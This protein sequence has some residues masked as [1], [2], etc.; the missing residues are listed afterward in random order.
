MPACPALAWLACMQFF[1]SKL[2]PSVVMFVIHEIANIGQ[3][4]IDA[5]RKLHPRMV[6][7]VMSPHIQRYADV[8]ILDNATRMA[9]QKTG[10][11]FMWFLDVMPWAPRL[12]GPVDDPPRYP[13]TRMFKRA[14]ALTPQ[15]LDGFV[16]NSA[17]ER[18]AKNLQPLWDGLEA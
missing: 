17:H 11:P 15:C 3:G 13:C 10:G 8:H 16:V 18:R 9:Y 5:M 7:S 6:F 12:S 2:Q 4:Q 1:L 14:K